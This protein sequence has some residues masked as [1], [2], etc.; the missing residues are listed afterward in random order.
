MASLSDID[1][2]L[3]NIQSTLNP[4][5]NQFIS[6]DGNGT[7]GNCMTRGSMMSFQA[8]SSVQI[9]AMQ[10]D[11]PSAPLGTTPI[12]PRMVPVNYAG[13]MVSEL[14]AQ[15]GFQEDEDQESEDE[16]EEQEP[17]DTENEEESQVVDNM[18][19]H[20]A[21]AWTDRFILK[22][23][24]K[25][26]HQTENSVLK[27][28]KSWASKA[29]NSG[30]LPDIIVDANHMIEY[31]KY[32]ATRQLFSRRGQKKPTTDRLSASSLKKIMTM[33]GHVCRRQE[34][35]NPQI[36]VS[37]PAKTSRTE[38]FYKAVMIQS[39]RLHLES[40][41]FHVMNG[42]IL[43]SE[44]HP[45]HF[46]EVT[47]AI[48]QEVNQLPS[49]IKAHFAWTWQC[50]MLNRSDELVSMLMALNQQVFEVLAMLYETKTAQPGKTEPT[51][52]F[53]LPHRNPLRC[54]V[55]ALA[56]LLHFMFDQ[57]KLLSHVPD[58]DWKNAASWRRVPLLFGRAVDRPITRDALGH[59]YSSFLEPTSITSNKKTHLARQSLPPV[60]EEIT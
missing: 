58:W 28:W 27:L 19:T 26:G 54:P 51:Y 60:L 44:L 35:E 7:D 15:S 52:S 25:S 4:A 47:A 48:F 12:D 46:N 43:D 11:A 20:D 40:E 33:L 5:A 17:G 39:Q 6:Q 18:K 50:S 37:R 13:C 3:H 55:G 41:D 57:E 23:R 38:D 2:A 29:I 24:R 21:L 59:M 16:E 1:P 8:Q 10:V 45:E 42:T 32:A 53:T 31:L 36:R 14:K 22:T 34:D 9:D 56:I 30:Q 49:I